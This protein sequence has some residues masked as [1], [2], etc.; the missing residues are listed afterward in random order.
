MSHELLE[1]SITHRRMEPRSSSTVR[2]FSP[3]FNRGQLVRLLRE[4]LPRVQAELPVTRAVLFG[5]WSRDQATAFSDIDLLIV[6]ADPVRDD[7]HKLV[8]KCIGLRGLE[9]HVYSDSEAA[10]IRP[11]LD[12]MARGGIDLLEP[13]PD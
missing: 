3:P 11:T 4:R 9:P 2:V 5:S 6:Y 12:Q 7:A 1:A 8:W 10:G 13:E